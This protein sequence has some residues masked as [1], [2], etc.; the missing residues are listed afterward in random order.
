MG[1]REQA[2]S[3]DFSGILE[4][5]VEQQLKEAAIIS[6]G[7]EISQEDLVSVHGM[8]AC[9]CNQ[10]DRLVAR[11]VGHENFLSWPALALRCHLSTCFVQALLY[12]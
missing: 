7:T 9:S 1:T 6:M 12:A 8:H 10:C 11:Q 5:D 2:A 3:N 4:E